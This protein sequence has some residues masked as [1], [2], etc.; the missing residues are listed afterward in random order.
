MGLA[1]IEA[2]KSTNE[3]PVGCIMVD[4]N[5]NVVSSAS[6][7]VE[8]S[9]SPIMHAEIECIQQTIEKTGEKFL[10]SYVMYVTLEPCMMC[11]GAICLSRVGDLFIGS[12]KDDSKSISL[13]SNYNTNHRPNIYFDIMKQ[14][15]DN[16]INV[17]FNNLR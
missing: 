9:K 4:K 2:K 16:L 13:L 12:R 8:K 11:F 10:N 1:I 6:N 3:I 7:T 17:F 5:G 15:C 14:E